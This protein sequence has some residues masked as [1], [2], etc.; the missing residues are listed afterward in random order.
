MSIAFS[1]LHDIIHTLITPYIHA[2]DRVKHSVVVFF[3]MS[4]SQQNIGNYAIGDLD[5]LIL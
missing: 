5:G 2:H 3:S 4:V 1:A